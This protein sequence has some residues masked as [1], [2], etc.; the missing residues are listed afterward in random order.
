M[1]KLIV[2]NENLVK[3]NYVT[4]KS[5]SKKIEILVN[6]LRLV[7]FDKEIKKRSLLIPDECEKYGFVE[8]YHNLSQLLHFLA[9][10]LEE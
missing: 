4:L 3:D 5:K 2:R 10:M 9:D 8:G 7:S 1:N 6:A